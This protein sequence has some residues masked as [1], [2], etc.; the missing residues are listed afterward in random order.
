V[1]SLLRRVGVALHVVRRSFALN[2]LDVKLRPY[3][4]F[5]RGFFVEAGANDGQT[6]SNTLYFERYLGWTGLLVEP[7]PALAERCRRNRPQCIVE[8]CALVPFGFAGESVEMHY[9]DLMSTVKGAMKSPEEEAR[10]LALGRE[11][12]Q[13]DTYEVR[14]PARTL[15]AVLDQHQI[16][17]IDFLSLDVE[18]FELSALQ[19]IDFEKHRPAVMLI[20]ARYR[21]E[22][23]SFLQP[24]YEPM[25]QLS[26]H[27]VLYKRR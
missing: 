9:C 15:S 12:Q 5:R 27:D 24:L 21:D 22:I 10:H 17:K 4:N 3:L 16:T 23:E 14:A 1:S 13:V 11:L 18:G 8:S 25:A 19:G 20:E 2:E 7:I 6:Q 26:E